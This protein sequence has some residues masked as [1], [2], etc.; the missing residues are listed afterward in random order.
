MLPTSFRS[1]ESDRR[2]WNPA[3]VPRNQEYGY[4]LPSIFELIQFQADL[5]V[6]VNNVLDTWGLIDPNRILVK[7]K[8][9]VLTHL[10]DDVRRFG[11]AVI[12]ATKIQECW[13]TIFRHEDGSSLQIVISEMTVWH[14][15]FT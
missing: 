13:N 4:L 1:L 9:H 7:G 2:A 5:E 14:R 11:P 12:F 6:F 10:V 15:F 8:I 3:L